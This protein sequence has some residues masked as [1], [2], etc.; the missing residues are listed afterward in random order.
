MCVHAASGPIVRISH[1]EVHIDDPEFY[2]TL[3]N[4]NP[5]LDKMEN[6]MGMFYGLVV[7]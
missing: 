1:R 2:E 4:F 5:Q 6:A 3:Y 7:Y